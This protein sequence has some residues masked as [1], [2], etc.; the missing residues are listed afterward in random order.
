MSGTTSDVDKLTTVLK[1]LLKE[2]SPA[3]RLPEGAL[4]G[5]ESACALL[6]YSFL[7][8]ESTPKHAATGIKQLGDAIIDLNDMRVALPHEI[9]EITGMR[10]GIALE[11]TERL[12]ATLN[13]IFRREHLVTLARLDSISKRE[14]RDYLDGLEGMPSFVS[15]RV[16][17]LGFGGHA[18]PL[19]ARLQKLLTSEGVFRNGT[20][21]DEAEHWLER[22]I[23]AADAV[24]IALLLEGWRNKDRQTTPK[25]DARD[26]Q[27]SAA[28]RNDRSTKDA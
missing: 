6:V 20:P 4:K 5:F 16:T 15:A 22:Q 28:E 13:D 2:H 7:L 10:D 23:R 9:V 19:D 24:D 12:R 27:D 14:V 25:K 11:R 18:I 1:R 21:M 3:E 26:P 17:L 8:W